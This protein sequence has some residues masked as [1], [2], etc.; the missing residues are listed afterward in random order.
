MTSTTSD[1][2]LGSKGFRL[3]SHT[4]T[5]AM[6]LA[7][8]LV[9]AIVVGFWLSRR[10]EKAVAASQALFLAQKS[11][12]EEQT[13]F[14]ESLR[15]ATPAVSVASKDKKAKNPPAP[16]AAPDIT[17]R[18]VNVE[19]TFKA[20]VPALQ[21]AA[22]QYSGTLAGTEAALTLADLYYRH[23]QWDRSA[24][25]F[26]KAQRSATV[27]LDKV[28]AWAGHAY[29]LENLGKR[30]A[31]VVSLER[32]LQVGEESWKGDLLLA[33][34]RNQAALKKSDAAKATY[35]RILKELPGTEAATTA[36][37]LKARLGGAQP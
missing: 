37:S 27:S 36:E 19:E 33:L 16:A 17:Y 8:I 35:E 2:V 31:A 5:L 29:A 15:P 20:G 7:G 30:D 23:G 22:T 1:V 12:S 28:S 9:A 34:A 10:E 4:R 21:L 26:E 11:L 18:R 24:E 13:K 6:V 14:S 32:A 3:S 25:W